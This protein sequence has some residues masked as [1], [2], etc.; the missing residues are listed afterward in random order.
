MGYYRLLD[1]TTCQKA[2]DLEILIFYSY[3]GVEVNCE[4]D[5]LIGMW[6]KYSKSLMTLEIF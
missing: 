4:N 5:I 3:L 6:I 1:L 2:R